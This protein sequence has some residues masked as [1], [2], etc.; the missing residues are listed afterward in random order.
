MP[1]NI[2]KNNVSIINNTPFDKN[3]PPSPS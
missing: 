1:K 2:V 3:I